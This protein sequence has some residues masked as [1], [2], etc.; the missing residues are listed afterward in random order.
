MRWVHAAPLNL[1]AV[2]VSAGEV[3]DALQRAD[4]D[5]KRLI[6]HEV[7]PTIEAKFGGFT[8]DFHPDRARALGF[9]CDASIDAIVQDYIK[10]GS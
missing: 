4:V 2:T 10:H 6:R 8:K 3:I 1:P 9:T 7:Q 5:A